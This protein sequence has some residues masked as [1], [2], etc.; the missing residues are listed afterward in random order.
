[1]V[2]A[3]L[4]DHDEATTEQAT[5]ESA[6]EFAFRTTALIMNE[7]QSARRVFQVEVANHGRIRWRDIG[8]LTPSAHLDATGP[9]TMAM[10]IIL[11]QHILNHILH[12]T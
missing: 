4:L 1:V 12:D 3:L 5:R 9:Q 11:T 7:C 2:F 6:K 10:I 8:P